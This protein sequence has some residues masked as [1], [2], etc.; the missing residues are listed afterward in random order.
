M[1]LTVKPL[2][3]EE[4]A[5]IKEHVAKCNSRE[6]FIQSYT[7]DYKKIRRRRLQGEFLGHFPMRKRIYWTEDALMKAASKYQTREEFSR[8]NNNAYNVGL[9]RKILDKI[10]AHMERQHYKY[11]EKLKKWLIKEVKKCKTKVNFCIEHR[12][13]YENIMARK[14]EWHYILDGLEKFYYTN[15]SL[16]E[17]SIRNY[18]NLI[19]ECN[20][21][22][23][24]PDWLINPKTG[25]KLELDGYDDNL[26]IAFE[27]NSN[28]YHDNKK[29]TDKIKRKICKKNGIALM[30]FPDIK[31]ELKFDTLLEMEKAI[32][33]IVNKSGLQIKNNDLRFA[34][35]PIFYNKK[36]SVEKLREVASKYVR[37]KDFMEKEQGAYQAI[38]SRKMCDKLLSHLQKGHLKKNYSDEYLWDVSLRYKTLESFRIAEGNIF[39][40]FYKRKHLKEKFK[41]YQRNLV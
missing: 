14:P 8:K 7:E 2:S 15:C 24:K 39:Y 22:K 35:S 16:G 37:L 23:T 13:I 29:D 40:E 34:W 36:W 26:K 27:Y 11:D 20:L 32:K 3:E 41:S 9:K 25:R 10:C 6:E 1:S 4:L 38:R 31:N 5:R 12:S 18:L 28:Y 30:V 19:L 33:K 21:E 17:E